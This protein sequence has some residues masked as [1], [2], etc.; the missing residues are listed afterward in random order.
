MDLLLSAQSVGL[1]ACFTAGC[2][3]AGG[4]LSQARARRRAGKLREPPRDTTPVEALA[5]GKRVL[6]AGTLK[7]KGSCCARLEDAM[8]V[9][10]TTFEQ[11]ERETE[12]DGAVLWCDR[13]LHL[14]VEVGKVS[15]VVDG[16]VRVLV[17]ADELYPAC[18]FDK[19]RGRVTERV[20]ASER[21]SAGKPSN[22]PRHGV[23]RSVGHGDQVV[24]AGHRRAGRQRRRPVEL[25]P[26]RRRLAT[27][28]RRDGHRASLVAKT[29]ARARRLWRDQHLRDRH[30]ALSHD[31]LRAMR[32]NWVMAVVMAGASM[33]CTIPKTPIYEPNKRIG[34]EFCTKLAARSQLISTEEMG[35]GIFMLTVA[36]ASVTAAGVLDDQRQLREPSRDP[37]L[38]GRRFGR[39]AVAA[40]AIRNCAHVT[41]G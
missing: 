36:G 5:G 11:R 37:R 41:L 17:G 35:V 15:I 1:A 32:S 2:M 8:P 3:V 34:F 30:L 7:V 14:R 16:P 10:A 39:G 18:R 20:H 28:P 38:R 40:G 25:S 6:V 23:F 22:T 19:L 33:G 9:A 12:A 29:P 26:A 24:I 31:K 4:V 27:A 21:Q 13:A